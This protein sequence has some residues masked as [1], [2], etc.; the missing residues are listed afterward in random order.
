MKQW[1]GR[2][3]IGVSAIHTVFA[4][5]VFKETLTTIIKRGVFDTI[6]E[7]PMLGAVAWFV[8]FGLVL[9]ISGLAIAE[10]EKSPSRPL[11]KSLGWS[12]L[13][14]GIVGVALMPASGLW[15][16]FPPALAVLFRKAAATSAPPAA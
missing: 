15:L 16:A 2:W 12:L 9:F 3:L 10:L 1:I 7:D 13:A 4:A 8:L 5:V 14:L 11:P 6:G